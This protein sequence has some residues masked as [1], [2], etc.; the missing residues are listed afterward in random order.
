MLLELFQ[1]TKNPQSEAVSY[2]LLGLWAQDY[3]RLAEA[4]R[5]MNRSIDLAKAGGAVLQ[6]ARYLQNRSLLHL[7]MARYGEAWDGMQAAGKIL[8]VYGNDED[9][10]LSRLHQIEFHSRTGNHSVASKL[11]LATSHELL[12]QRAQHWR[13]EGEFEKAE[14]DLQAALDTTETGTTLA[15]R[16]KISMARLGLAEAFDE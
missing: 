6:G 4:E 2:H 8:R 14:A 13:R 5:L 1:K 10:S 7:E 3:G 16:I 12:Y 11:S 9:L 15:T